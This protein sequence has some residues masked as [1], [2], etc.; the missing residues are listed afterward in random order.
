ML[1]KVAKWA[2]RFKETTKDLDLDLDLDPKTI[3]ITNL[4][5]QIW[6]K[7][8]GLLGKREKQQMIWFSSM[9]SIKLQ[10]CMKL[11]PERFAVGETN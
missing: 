6:V 3:K 8:R 1:L 2:Q 7:K 5:I 9:A 11:I 10:G 4:R